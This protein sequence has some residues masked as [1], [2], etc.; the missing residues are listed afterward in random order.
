MPFKDSDDVYQCLGSLFDWATQQKDLSD[1]LSTL[2]LT[3]KIKLTNPDAYM[4]LDCTKSPPTWQKTDANGAAN[5]EFSMKAADANKFWLGKMNLPVAVMMGQVKVKGQV[6]KV[7]GM[8]SLL[9]P[10]N[11]R[12]AEILTEKGR[13][14]L[15]NLQ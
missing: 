11:K 9:G 15:L 5:V 8:L 14:D 7:M 3:I 12:Y 2:G 6:T 1:K 13:T 10:M 4:L